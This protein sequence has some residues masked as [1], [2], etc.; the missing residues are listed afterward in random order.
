[1]LDGFTRILAGCATL[2]RPGG[3]VVVTARPWR[4]HGE[5]ADLPSAV[6][7]AGAARD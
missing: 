3:I 2:L 5:L 6:L 4:H 1:M 7:A